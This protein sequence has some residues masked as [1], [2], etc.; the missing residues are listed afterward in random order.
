MYQ[1][2]LNYI[3]AIPH[4]AILTTNSSRGNKIGRAG[5]VSEIQAFLGI[6][7]VGNLNDNES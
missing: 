5:L 3:P 4:M 1:F 6:N 2:F 7:S